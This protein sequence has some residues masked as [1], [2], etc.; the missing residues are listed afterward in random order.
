[1][2][3]R[4]SQADNRGSNFL[5]LLASGKGKEFHTFRSAQSS[6]PA[7]IVATGGS[8]TPS[9]GLEVDGYTYHFFTASSTPGFDVS[10]VTGPGS[11]EYLVVAGGGGAGG[12]DGSYW[13]GGR[14]GNSVL[15]SPTSSETVTS[16]GGGAGRY[17]ATADQ[18]GGS[19]GGAPAGIG[20]GYNPSTPPG[21][22]S[23][24]PLPYPYGETQGYPS[25]ANTHGGGG[26]AGQAGQPGNPPDHP[27]SIPTLGK[28]GDGKTAFN[29]AGIPTDYGTT[30][31]TPGRWFAGGG[32]SGGGTPFIEGPGGAGGGGWGICTPKA[33]INPIDHRN[34]PGAP[35]D[36]ADTNG[37]TNTGGGGG[38][39]G[40]APPVSTASGGG[41]AGGF[42]TGELTVNASP[43][44][45]PITIGGGGTGDST[46][47]VGG[48]G[49]VIIRYAS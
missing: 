15:T 2:A 30:G 38:G 41:G 24:I 35:T 40:T 45:Y 12:Y 13:N 3:G 18:P 9:S 7:G 46:K 20:Y 10:E 39:V 25:G 42:M 14:G 23:P 11:V 49:I 34:A 16:Y 47:A 1:M 44:A 6:N 32:G 28:G 37:A 48:S 33:G 27:E 22:L 4:S 21:I 29:G 8:Q 43:G 17:S 36:V 5:G 26:G 31:P 19:G